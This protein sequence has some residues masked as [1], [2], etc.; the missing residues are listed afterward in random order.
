MALQSAQQDLRDT[1][2]KAVN[3]GL[4]RLQYL[5]DL[6]DSDSDTYSH[7]GLAR[8]Y[9]VEAASKALAEEH[10]QLLASLLSAPLITLL[11]DLDW[12]SQTS[13]LDPA[14]F[15]E[16]LRARKTASL[17][18]PN[19]GAG[20]ESHLSSVLDALSALLDSPA[21]AIHRA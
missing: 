2:L 19:P 7:W 18:P 9:G 21:C 6:R 11:N 1:S 16:R 13:G 15:V 10:R 4:N 12:C 20:A 3:G 17:L 8:V 14:T 5:A